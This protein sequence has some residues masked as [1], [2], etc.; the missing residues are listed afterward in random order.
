MVGGA[1]I[2]C[3][4]DFSGVKTRESSVLCKFTVI[5]RKEIFGV[6]NLIYPFVYDIINLCSPSI[7][8][9]KY[10]RLGGGIDEKRNLLAG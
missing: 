5:K 10:K 6:K 3:F 8:K 7:D 9:K 4:N 2:C 1:K